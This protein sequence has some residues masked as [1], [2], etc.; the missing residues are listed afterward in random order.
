MARHRW[1]VGFVAG[2]LF[3]ASSLSL[4]GADNTPAPGTILK[5]FRPRMEG[6][7]YVV[8]PAPQHDACK[9][10]LVKGA[11]GGSGWLVRDPQGRALCRFF[12][13]NA[14]RKVDV[15]SYYKDG[16][17]IYREIDSDHKGQ[18][19]TANEYRWL[20]AGGARWGVDVD[21][22]G[23]IDAWRMISPEEVSQE[24]L[25]ALITKDFGRLQA[26]WISDAELKAVEL[27][28]AEASRIQDARRQGASKFQQMAAKLA[29]N[30]KT[31]WLRLETSPPQCLLAETLG[32]R[33]DVLKYTN[34]TILYEHSGK[35]DFLQLGE[36]MQVGAAWRLIESPGE[37][38][39]A[40]TSSN[41]VA[42]ADP[43]VQ[44][45]LDQL[46]EM[47]KKPMP[48][49]VPG[50]NDALAKFNLQRADLIEVI[51]S[52]VK[53]DDREQWIRQLAD[54][55]GAA[56][57]YSAE[58]DK[59]AARRL[60]SLVE[61]LAKAMPAGHPLT[62]YVIFRD[63][64]ADYAVQLARGKD[65]DKVQTAWLEKLVKFVTDYPKAEDTPDALLQLGMVH[66]FTGKE[67]EAK[68]WYDHLARN[69]ADHPL[70]LKALGA[71]RRLES[72]GKVLEL[73]GPILGGGKFDLAQL[74]G[75]LVVVYYW[76]SWNQQ[77]VG[78][79]AKLKLLLDTHAS[80]GLAVVC[81][82]LDET[83][84]KAAAFL[85][86]IQAPG[87]HLHQPG[88]LDS[89]LATQYGVMVLPN[90]FLVKDGKVLNRTVQVANLEDE[91]KKAAK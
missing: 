38:G 53:P 83:A 55:L 82:N 87:T 77:C 45:L 69:F 32:T 12:D 64:S 91:I 42:Q 43:E 79:F 81:V 73:S 33:Q 62:G 74:K 31:Q 71:V 6:V 54:C 5:S 41:S 70:A 57:Q 10:E 48:A 49:S 18:G 24:V 89:P 61:Q 76:A 4:H 66:E 11:R 67:P 65:L 44:K 26:L 72:E 34:A 9:V 7:P 56:V 2:C 30:E 8:P 19:K 86:K 16:I 1:G 75:K 78:D 28:A 88:G 59:A 58:S 80:K 15:W 29:L 13:S 27:P 46:R 3:A 21:R 47:D 35:H 63:I 84:D 90:L 51:V 23:K 52:K 25:Q 60:T 50:A 14:D 68:K 22:D 36:M 40:G 20:N 85:Q 39:S 17:E 37:G